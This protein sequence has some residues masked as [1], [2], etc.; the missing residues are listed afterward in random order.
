LKFN[1][2]IERENRRVVT[3]LTLVAT[4]FGNHSRALR[5]RFAR[6][7]QGLDLSRQVS[8]PASWFSSFSNYPSPMRIGIFNTFMGLMRG[9]GEVDALGFGEEMRRR[10]HDVTFI[11]GRSPFRKL[12]TV[13]SEVPIIYVT[14]VFE[15]YELTRTTSGVVQRAIYR[16]YREAHSVALRKAF[17]G[18]EVIHTHNL[19]VAA[20][21]LRRRSDHQVVALTLHGQPEPVDAPLLRQVDV[22]TS[23]G[24][25]LSRQ[26]SR[27]VGVPC[28]FVPAGMDLELFAPNSKAEARRRLRLPDLP[29]VLFVGRLIAVKRIDLLLRAMRRLADNGIRA[30]T[31][32]VGHGVLEGEMRGLVRDLGL[33]ARFDGGVQLQDVPLYY[34]AADVLVLPSEYES[35]GR[36]VIEALAC[37]CPVIVSDRVAARGMFEEIETV[38]FGDTEALSLRI[39]SVLKHGRRQVDR[40]RLSEVSWSRVAER[41]EHLFAAAREARASSAQF[42]RQ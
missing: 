41:Y 7:Y 1:T 18:Y 24:D 30:Q 26:V 12:L 16:L 34:Q 5:L 31:V 38:P 13:S 25:A 29:V 36:V 4:Q 23:T 17:R 6:Q 42:I 10:G 27:D 32:L 40:A 3:L 35:F 33:P 8:R 15:L 28:E 22:L 39:A 14:N 21:A 2:G 19:D 11:A 37:G 9:G 20:N